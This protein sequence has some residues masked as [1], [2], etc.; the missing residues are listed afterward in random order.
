MDVSTVEDTSTPMMIDDNEE[1]ISDYIDLVL[2]AIVQNTKRHQEFLLNP[3]PDL[4]RQMAEHSEYITN[5]E[6]CLNVHIRRIIR[7]F[8]TQIG[9]DVCMQASSHPTDENQGNANKNN[10]A[11]ATKAECKDKNDADAE[12][13]LKMNI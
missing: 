13:K 7:N 2:F 6:N 3:N 12:T 10:N 4:S 9:Y 5:A 11:I 1:A 8:K